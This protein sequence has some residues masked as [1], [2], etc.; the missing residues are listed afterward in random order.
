MLHKFQ[1]LI[2]C[3]LG[4]WRKYKKALVFGA[5]A[6][7]LSLFPIRPGLAQVVNVGCSQNLQT[8]GHV[9]CSAGTLRIRPNGT[10]VVTGCLA[11]L[12]APQAAQCTISVT[13]GVAT[14]NV[15]V[16]F[17]TQPVNITGGGGTATLNDFKLEKTTTAGTAASLTYTPLQ[18]A[19]PVNVNVGTTMTFSD[20]QT[21][22]AYTGGV[23]IRARFN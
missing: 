1:P 13:G 9:A 21:A 19:A 5:S 2:I 4:Q 22:G 6:L 16:D 8:G 7:A 10:T 20:K 3:G 14:R 12:S 18:I 15:I 23:N 17:P 11:T